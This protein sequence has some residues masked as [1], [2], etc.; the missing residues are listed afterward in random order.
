VIK[1]LRQVALLEG[2]LECAEEEMKA[3]EVKFAPNLGRDLENMRKH[4]IPFL[5][6]EII[7]RYYYQYGNIRHALPADKQYRS[8]VD[9]LKDKEAYDKLLTVEK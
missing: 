3:L 1:L 6:G 5:E 2:Y 4:I 9:L 8:A 7:S